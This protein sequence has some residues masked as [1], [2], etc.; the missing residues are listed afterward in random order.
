MISDILHVTQDEASIKEAL[1]QAEAVAAYR[2]LEK[3]AA[4]ELRL[5]TEEMMGLVQALTGQREADFWIESEGLKFQLHLKADAIVNTEMRKRLLSVSSNGKNA[6]AKGFMAKIRDLFERS[7]EPA[8]ADEEATLA[9]G[10]YYNYSHEFGDIGFTNAYV[11][12]LNRYRES[13]QTNPKPKETWDELE[14]SVVA[15]IAD[16]VVMGIKKNTIEMVIYKKF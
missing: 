5:L 1:M 9:S 7:M 12:S 11:W 14:K 10:A 4:L 3:K 15:K 16:E 13:I 8:D 6:S 2:G